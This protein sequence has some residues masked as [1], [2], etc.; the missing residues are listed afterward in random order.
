VN[1]VRGND[2]RRAV[3]FAL[4]ASRLR[5]F[6]RGVTLFA[7]RENP[8][9]LMLKPQDLLVASA[10]A[11]GASPAY[12]AL[13]GVV[14]LSLSETHAAVQRLI[15]C[16]LVSQDRELN[17]HQFAELVVHGARYV[18]PLVIG[19]V[20]VGLPTA[21]AAPMLRELTEFPEP[22]DLPLVWEMPG[23]PQA[24]RGLLVAPLYPSVAAAA[25]GNQSLYGML[26][27]LDAARVVGSVRERNAAKNE[28]RR[29]L[30]LS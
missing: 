4:L 21:S 6:G 26:A 28:L 20:G 2:Q 24:M 7:D 15:R 5:P 16:G 30:G 27:L 23:H 10:L 29:Q 22:S 1:E 11:V 9:T 12:D 3:T 17:A 19:S 25:A 14:G 13:C 18:W 8:E